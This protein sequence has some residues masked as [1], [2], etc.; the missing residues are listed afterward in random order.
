MGVDDLICGHKNEKR[1]D[2]FSEYFG[3]VNLLPLDLVD[4]QGNVWA[5]WAADSLLLTSR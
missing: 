3:K 1:G 5:G 4:S 2:L